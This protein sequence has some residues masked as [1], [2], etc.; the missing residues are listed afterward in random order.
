[1]C[2]LLGEYIRAVIVI[3]AGV[4]LTRICDESKP[5]ATTT[6]FES[7]PRDL[8][9]FTH[10]KTANYKTLA[11]QKVK[12]THCENVMGDFV[13]LLFEILNRIF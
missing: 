3:F 10:N 1:M 2:S 4:I 13:P 5:M 11:T 6:A 12:Y 9:F 7:I 8:D